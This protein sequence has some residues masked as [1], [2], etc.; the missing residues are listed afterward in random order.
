MF[1]KI[2][3][4]IKRT[5]ETNQT[6]VNDGHIRNSAFT[7]GIAKAY[8]DLLWSMGHKAFIGVRL[9]NGC[10]KISYVEIDGVRLVCDG[11]IDRNSYKKLRKM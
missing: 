4:K 2:I 9:N 7:T 1:R 3:K 8:A 6:F 10:D 11:E 5:V